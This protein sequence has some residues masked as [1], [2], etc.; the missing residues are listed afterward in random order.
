MTE[1]NV[2][3]NEKL[4]EKI[5]KLFEATQEQSG[6]QNIVEAAKKLYNKQVTLVKHAFI[7]VKL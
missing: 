5:K 2:L 4:R 1:N 7:P 6:C 3:S